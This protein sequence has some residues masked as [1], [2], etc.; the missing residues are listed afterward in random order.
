MEEL[1]VQGSEFDLLFH[2]LELLQIFK[3]M[4]LAKWKN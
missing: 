3:V 2:G 4:G 1:R